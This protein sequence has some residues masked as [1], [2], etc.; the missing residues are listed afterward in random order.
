MSKEILINIEPQEKRA[1][2]VSAGR[3]EEF[4]IEPIKTTVDFHK[5]VFNNSDFQRGDI[6]TH[7]IE[8]FFPS[9]EEK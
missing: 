8:K 9:K 4:Y 3:L 2:I 1:A 7:F 6:S 5:Q